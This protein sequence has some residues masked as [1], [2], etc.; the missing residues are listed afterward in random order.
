VLKIFKKEK[1]L[2]HMLF[3]VDAFTEEPFRGNPAGVCLLQAPESD[4]WMQALAEEMNLSETAYLLPEGD[5]WRLRWFTPTTEVDLCGH[6]TLAS[7]RVLFEHHPELRDDLIKFQTRSGE[8]SARWV[9]GAVELDFPAM[10]YKG[11]TVD[12]RVPKILGFHPIGAV[13]SGDYYLFEAIDEQLVREAQPNIP[14]LKALPMPEVII[15]AK[16]EKAEVDFVSRFFAPQ[17][18]IDED[19]V[20][21]SAHC[22]LMPYWAK[23]LGKNT[24]DAFQASSRG[25]F[26]HLRLA[27]DRVFMTGAARIIFQA[28]LLL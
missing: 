10:V 4:K 22:L 1:N 16:S 6:A 23:K 17:L 13:F 3:Q 20:T 27:G 9:D 2:T 5:A 21:G 25:G 11:I 18:G 8:L 14:A 26:L 7:A 12:A 28:N 15:T 24:M 19:P